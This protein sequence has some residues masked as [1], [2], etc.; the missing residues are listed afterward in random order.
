M[1]HKDCKY[2]DGKGEGL[3][4]CLAH[5][6]VV[7]IDRANSVATPDL[8]NYPTVERN[9]KACGEFVLKEE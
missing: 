6:P 9:G 2:Y 7:T 5:P 4:L 8:W 1:K 3:G